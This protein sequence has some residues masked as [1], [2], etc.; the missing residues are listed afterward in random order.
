MKSTEQTVS[1][2][3][4]DLAWLLNQHDCEFYD[5]LMFYMP[6]GEFLFLSPST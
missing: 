6:E 2:A 1:H 5:I 3:S 4:D